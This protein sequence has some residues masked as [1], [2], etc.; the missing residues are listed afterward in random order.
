MAPAI[1]VSYCVGSVHAEQIFSSNDADHSFNG[2][3]TAPQSDGASQG[4]EIDVRLIK[5]KQRELP[6]E[7]WQIE[8]CA[9]ERHQQIVLRE[10]VA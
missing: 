2:L 6:I 7:H 4:I 5:R 10:F 1:P 9:A 3:Q 8:A